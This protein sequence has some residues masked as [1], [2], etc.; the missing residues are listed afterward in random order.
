MEDA[1]VVVTEEVIPLEKW[2]Q[3]NTE[4]QKTI[5]EKDTLIQE[6]IWGIKCILDGLNF[7]HNN[8]NIIHG[9][10]GLHSCFV[11]KNGDWKLGALDLTCNIF[12][13]N[14]FFTANEHLLGKPFR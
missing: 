8:C 6:I 10:I 11:A 1:I 14:S 5:E 7:L 13:D 2:L 3:L 9:Y 12:D 4:S